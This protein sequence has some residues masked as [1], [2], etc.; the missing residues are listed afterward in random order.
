MSSKIFIG[1]RHQA[2][3]FLKAKSN[4]LVTIHNIQSHVKNFSPL[5]DSGKTFIYNNPNSEEIKLISSLVDKNQGEHCLLF[6]DESFDGR[7]SLIQKIRKS[8]NIYNF[9]YPVLGD[10]TELK[11]RVLHFVKS[12]DIEIENDCFQWIS[13][14]CP[15]YRIKSKESG[16]KKETLTYDIELLFQELYKISSYAE[17]ITIEELEESNFKTDSDIFIFIDQI[18]NKKLSEALVSAQLLSYSMGEQGKLLILLNQLLLLLHVYQC[19]EENINNTDEVL[20][21]LENRDLI[22]KYLS[23]SWEI[24]SA[25]IKSQNPTRIR[26]ELSKDHKSTIQICKMIQFVVETIKDLRNQGNKDIA[27]FLLLNKLQ[28]V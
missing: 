15:I 5:F 9:S 25:P 14:N 28:I 19:K 22:A 3:V 1:S 10:T 23:E 11:R 7:L 24:I 12:I 20:K 21:R 17:K 26:I 16:S 2:Y 18:L 6:D 27:M 8:N 13:E 4:S